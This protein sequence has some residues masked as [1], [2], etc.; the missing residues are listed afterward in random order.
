MS[1]LERWLRGMAV[2]RCTGW[3]RRKRRRGGVWGVGHASGKHRGCG[4]K[5]SVT[6]EGHCTCRRKIS[7]RCEGIYYEFGGFMSRWA[8]GYR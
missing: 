2:E 3:R 8:V 7:R 1:R 6:V 4:M 5:E